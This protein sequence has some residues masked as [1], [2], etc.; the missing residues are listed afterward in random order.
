MFRRPAVAALFA[1]ALAALA[2]AIQTP[3][4]SAAGR[5]PGDVGMIV[6]DLSREVRHATGFRGHGV[7]V[8]QVFPGGPADR[9]DLREGDIIFEFENHEVTT[10]AAMMGEIR[11]MIKGELASLKYWRDGSTGW[12][13]LSVDE[14]V[15]LPAPEEL[16]AASRAALDER[17]ATFEREFDDRSA[18]LER[19]FADHAKNLER[20]IDDLR[21]RVAALEAV[22]APP[23]AP[24]DTTAVLDE[25]GDD[26]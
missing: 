9:E 18:N 24:A 17:F 23:T 13:L 1:C 20:E 4:P 25:G 6:G 3:S 7:I 5:N 19:E 16:E 11:S 8:L 10:A 21:A 26:R 2:L 12:E 22:Q 15:P 14:L